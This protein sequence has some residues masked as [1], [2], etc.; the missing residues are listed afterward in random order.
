MS[1]TGIR[2][3]ITYTQD[4]EPATPETGDVWINTTGG[5][6]VNAYHIKVWNG[7]GWVLFADLYSSNNYGY[8]IGGETPPTSSGG[9]LSTPALDWIDRYDFS[10]EGQVKRCGYTRDNYVTSCGYANSSVSGYTF[11]TGTVNGTSYVPGSF[12]N[13]CKFDFPFDSG[14][15]N[16]IGSLAGTRYFGMGFNSSSKGYYGGGVILAGL[17][18]GMYEVESVSYP[19]STGVAVTESN[20]PYAH[21][22]GCAHN[23]S[24]K[25]YVCGGKESPPSVPTYHDDVSGWTF[26][27]DSSNSLMSALGANKMRMFGFN[28][29]I[30]G[31]VAGHT[32]LASYSNIM[33]SHFFASEAIFINHIE[34]LATGK[35]SGAAYNSSQFGYAAGGIATG[36]VFVKDVQRWPFAYA[37]NAVVTGE[38]SFENAHCIGGD[39]TDF[40]TMF[41]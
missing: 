7:S 30:R 12:D 18:T 15:I 10:F 1:I 29:S 39:Q 34:V 4:S 22:R 32:E 35:G 3:I 27:T 31:H 26:S 19:F 28:S 33:T 41:R 37:A 23:S 11:G 9:E 21:G 38:L 5:S 25:G 24:L 16:N 20:L 14:I 40:V 13:I 36:P 8:I 6:V 2:S 17:G